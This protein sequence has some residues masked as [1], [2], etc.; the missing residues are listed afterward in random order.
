MNHATPIT[1]ALFCSMAFA[2]FLPQRAAAEDP[3]AVV[4]YRF[5]HIE[6]NEFDDTNPIRP[7]FD[8][9]ASP[10]NAIC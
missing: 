9:G 10:D 1:C 7:D 4:G 2:T 3:R 5:E 6:R 8:W